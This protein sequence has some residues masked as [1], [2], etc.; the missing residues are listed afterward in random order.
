MWLVEIGE[1]TG[2]KKAEVNTVKQFISKTTDRYR[3][4]Y[5]KRTENF[6]RQCVFF[7]TTNTREFLRDETGDRR[8][9][10]LDSGYKESTKNVFDD[11]THNEVDQIWAEALY[12]YQKGEK[13]YLSNDLEE[14]A[15][16]IQREHREVDDRVS[17]VEEYL[18]I[19]LPTDWYEM[20]KT[21]RVIKGLCKDKGLVQ[22]KSGQ[23]VLAVKK[24]T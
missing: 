7:G 5:G 12:L 2:L 15:R 3:V 9:W 20:C 22:W 21:D 16:E 13:L 18:D 11:L 19:L 10:V 23:S 4:S 8:W 24:K 14:V 1:L 6:P 17:M